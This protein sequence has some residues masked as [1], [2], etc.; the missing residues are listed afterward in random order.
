ML[1]SNV[2]E[3][4]SRRKSTFENSKAT[5]QMYKHTWQTPTH[6]AISDTSTLIVSG[7]HVAH[8]IYSKVSMVA[9]AEL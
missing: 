8:Q 4:G 5:S 6:E 9:K 3:I 7:G 1:I 2:N